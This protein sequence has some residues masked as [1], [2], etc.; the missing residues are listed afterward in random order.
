[1]DFSAVKRWRKQKD[2]LDFLVVFEIRVRVC[3][4]CQKIEAAYSTVHVQRQIKYTI[5]LKVRGIIKPKRCRRDTP[6]GVKGT[7]TR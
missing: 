7:R 6:D 3:K 4:F 5:Y 1:M 2:A